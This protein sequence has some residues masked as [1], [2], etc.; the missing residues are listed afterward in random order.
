LAVADTRVTLT[1][2]G[3]KATG[4]GGCNTYH[5]SYQG[6]GA[7]DTLS[8][9]PVAATKKACDQAVSDQEQAFFVALGEVATYGVGSDLL[10]LSDGEGAVLLEFRAPGD[11]I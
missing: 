10:T 9:G 3:G 1:M 4:S 5:A 8:F 11:R 2:S 7:G 6:G